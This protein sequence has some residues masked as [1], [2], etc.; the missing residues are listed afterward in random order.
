MP[1]LVLQTWNINILE[2]T[3]VKTYKPSWLFQFHDGELDFSILGVQTGSVFIV[4]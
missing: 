3:R 2:P 4:V 1:F